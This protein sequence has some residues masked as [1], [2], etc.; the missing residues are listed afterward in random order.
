[1]RWGLKSMLLEK[2]KKCGEQ[3]EVTGKIYAIYLVQGKGN[4]QWFSL[5]I[6]SIY[7]NHNEKLLIDY[8][9]K[10]N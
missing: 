9:L 6:H 1:M 4:V 10:T 5:I 8:T 2:K 7:L 3:E